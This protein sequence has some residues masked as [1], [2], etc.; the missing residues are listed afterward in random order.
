MEGHVED[1]FGVDKHG[2]NMIRLI[3]A[4]VLCT[5]GE[6]KPPWNMRLRLTDLSFARDCLDCSTH[7]QRRLLSSRSPL[8]AFH[9]VDGEM[10]EVPVHLLH[11][12]IGV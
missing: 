2:V 12:G 10:A 4:E 8:H 9:G 5:N 1:W 11:L 3:E 6:F 7:A